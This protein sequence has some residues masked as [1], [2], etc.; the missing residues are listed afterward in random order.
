MLFYCPESGLGSGHDGD[1]GS[2]YFRYR[3]WEKTVRPTLERV[4]NNSLVDGSKTTYLHVV[5]CVPVEPRNHWKL[6]LNTEL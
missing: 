1:T 4:P 5:P 2:D 3:N 6:L